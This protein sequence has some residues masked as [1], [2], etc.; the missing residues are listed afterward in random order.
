MVN[1]SKFIA[2]VATALPI[3]PTTQSLYI[4]TSQ[5][6]SIWCHS[7]MCFLEMRA[8]HTHIS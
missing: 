5:D 6:I 8:S 1:L 2:V 7:D 3:Q 4:L